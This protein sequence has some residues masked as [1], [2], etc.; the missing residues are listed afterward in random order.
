MG[1]AVAI[2]RRGL[3]LSETPPTREAT[4]PT[5]NGGHVT[6]CVPARNRSKHVWSHW[7]KIKTALK[8]AHVAHGRSGVPKGM[9]APLSPEMRALGAIRPF[10]AH[11]RD[12]NRQQHCSADVTASL[13]SPAAY[14]A[15]DRFE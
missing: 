15:V 4:V 8:A 3:G 9:P 5:R 14:M 1:A 13:S 10:T 2:A 12:A 11:C 7:G 6:F